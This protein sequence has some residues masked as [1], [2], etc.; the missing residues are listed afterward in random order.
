[1]DVHIFK[2]ESEHVQRPVKRQTHSSFSRDT[3]RDAP[4]P[5]SGGILLN[6]S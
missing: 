4:S 2:K 1:M 5:G 6:A 3:P